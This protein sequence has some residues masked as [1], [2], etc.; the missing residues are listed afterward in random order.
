MN[1]VELERKELTRQIDGFWA[2]R[3]LT[4]EDQKRC[5]ALMAKLANLKSEDER[6][7]KIAQVGSELGL[8]FNASTPTEASATERDLRNYFAYGKE[9][10]TYAGMSVTTDA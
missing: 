6:R 5:D 7:S 1:A 2:K 3:K 9:A 10:R 8:N 4:R